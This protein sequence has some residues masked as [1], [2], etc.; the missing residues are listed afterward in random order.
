MDS[1]AL[2]VLVGYNTENVSHLKEIIDKRIDKLVITDAVQNEIKKI[3]SS[4]SEKKYKD[5]LDKYQSAMIEVIA[6]REAVEEAE[7][8]HASIR[9]DQTGKAAA[10][11]IRVKSKALEDKGIKNIEELPYDKYEESLEWLYN[12]AKDDRTI[13]GEAAATAKKGKTVLITN[14]YDIKMLSEIAPENLEI[15]GSEDIQE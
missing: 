4:N 15:V 2:L 11:W 10:E 1:S 8:Y 5:R 14:D 13:Y 12:A 6:N 7:R 3:L 9:D